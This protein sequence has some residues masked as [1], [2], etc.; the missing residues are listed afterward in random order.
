MPR[1][2]QSAATPASDRQTA[3]EQLFAERCPIAEHLIDLAGIQAIAGGDYRLI[4]A[5]LAVARAVKQCVSLN[6][7]IAEMRRVVE[8]ENQRVDSTLTMLA[9]VLRGD[10]TADQME[11]FFSDG[12]SDKR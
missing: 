4:Q 6:D 8:T 11:S 2:I 9:H 1:D 10:T 3:V 7:V 5:K 12:L